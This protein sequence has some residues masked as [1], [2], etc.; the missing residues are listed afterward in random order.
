MKNLK[1]KI[2]N[3]SG[4]LENKAWDAVFDYANKEAKD[5]SEFLRF[6]MDIIKGNIK[7]N[8]VKRLEVEKKMKELGYTYIEKL[9]SM[10]AY[11]FTKEKA[12]EAKNKLQE[13]KQ[14]EIEFKESYINLNVL[15][16]V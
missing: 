13:K 5:V 10:P 11:N 15:G 2:I 16:V 8:N 9:I 14:V 7:I 3:E 1:E 6:I 12:D 4:N